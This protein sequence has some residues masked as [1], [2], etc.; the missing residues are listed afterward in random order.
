[1]GVECKEED[2]TENTSSRVVYLPVI[3]ATVGSDVLDVSGVHK[4]TGCYIYDPGFSSTASCDSKITFIN[5]ENGYLQYRGYPIEVLAEKSTF[6]EVCC[7]LFFGELPT[8]EK[9]DNFCDRVRTSRKIDTQKI[10]DIFKCY[11]RSLHPM[12]IL[13]AVLTYLAAEDHPSIN[14]QNE[15]YRV[16]TM[17]NLIGNIPII[18]A[19]IIR[20]VQNKPLF[21]ALDSQGKSLAEWT[22]DMLLS[23]EVDMTPKILAKFVRAMEVVLILHADHEQNASTSAVRGVGSTECGPYASV[24][25]GVAALWGPSHGG[26]N[27]AV[28]QM[29]DEICKSGNPV[30]H[31]VDRAQDR[32]DPFR[33]MGFGHRVYKNYDPRARIIREICLDILS[34]FKRDANKPL[35]SIAQELEEYALKSDYFIQRRLYPNVDF[36]SGII[37]KS[38]GVPENAF[39]LIFALSRVIGWISHWH[40][41]VSQSFRISRPRQLYTGPSKR[42]YIKIEER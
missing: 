35:F 33:L 7:L 21:V 30:S 9:L 40:E 41:M 31:Y 29:L 27:E 2:E 8:R 24:V 19:A 6:E 34:S 11:G 3:E 16:N 32:N 15:A 23:D 25:A 26:A 5:G 22:V 10:K 39:T 28:L 20:H 38:M 12:A 1:M 18:I 36:Y 37:F 4:D 17:F 42:G 13:M 14:L